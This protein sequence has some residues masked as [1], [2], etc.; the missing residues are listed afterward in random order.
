MEILCE[1]IMGVYLGSNAVYFTDNKSVNVEPSVMA[2]LIQKTI[3]SYSNSRVSFIGDTA[4]RFCHELVSIDLP[5]VLSLKYQAFESCDSLVSVSFPKLITVGSSAFGHCSLLYSINLP[6]A[7][8]LSSY[9]FEYCYFLTTVSIPQVQSI[10]RFVFDTCRLLSTI[11]LPCVTRIES[12]AFY[13]CNNLLSIYLMGSS[14][15]VL[16]S[17]NVFLTTPISD[18][19]GSTGGVYGS[20]YVPASLYNSYLTATNWSEYSARLKSI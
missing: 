2:D 10:G 4:F 5:N 15:P 19:T 12:Y 8:T 6:Q 17:T 16:V 1:E 18:Y 13:S 3:V 9:A 7:I 11:S 14:I 20:I